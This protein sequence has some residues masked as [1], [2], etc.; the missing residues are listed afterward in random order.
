VI[1][2]TVATAHH[3]DEESEWNVVTI[4]VERGKRGPTSMKVVDSQRITHE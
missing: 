3:A 2:V 1:T 4:D